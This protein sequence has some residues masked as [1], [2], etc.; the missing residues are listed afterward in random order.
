[1]SPRRIAIAAS[2]TAFLI[3]GSAGFGLAQTVGVTGAV[4]PNATGTPPGSTVRALG[5][6]NDVIFNERITTE[7]KG[8]ADVLFV[9]RSALTIG[10]NSDLVI[11]E[12]VYSP[13]TGT[14]KLA[15][16]ATKGVFRFVGGAL[17]KNPDSVTIKTPA[18]IVGVRGGVIML[19]INQNGGGSLYFL[20]GD[21][22]SV[23]SPS[24]H[25][26][27]R[28][29]S[30]GLDFGPDGKI[31]DAH[32]A[33]PAAL[34]ALLA[35]FKG[36]GNGGATPP[37]TEQGLAGGPT[38]FIDDD[39]DTNQIDLRNYLRP[40]DAFDIFQIE[41]LYKTRQPKH[42]VIIICTDCCTANCG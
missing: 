18:A 38:L 6:G 19:A 8:Q 34:Q 31:G 40:V 20:Y 24:G 35:L 23:D 25:Q 21:Q 30:W 17:S 27:L 28:R 37:P 41:S 29:R 5:T 9:D 32:P 16:S 14:G 22:V 4:N 2:T 12:F 36:T 42:G 1:M 33:D 13:D 11:D 7:A 10:P 26:D 39:I 15:A 3:L